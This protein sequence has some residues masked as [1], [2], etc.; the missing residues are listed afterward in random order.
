MAQP[1]KQINFDDIV[2]APDDAESF[3]MVWNN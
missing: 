3:S 2:E 1:N